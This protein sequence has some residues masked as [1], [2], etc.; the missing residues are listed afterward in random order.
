[1]IIAM[2]AAPQF[3]LATFQRCEVCGDLFNSKDIC[4]VA[5]HMLVDHALVS[6]AGRETA[7]SL[8]RCL[9][10]REAGAACKAS[11]WN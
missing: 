9:A 4:S 3:V 7:L 11:A 6:R 5:F 2:I 8:A 10:A 1:M